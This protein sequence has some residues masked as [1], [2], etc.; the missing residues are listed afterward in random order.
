MLR[1]DDAL[2]YAA[3]IL[4]SRTDWALDS[5]GGS[6][7]DNHDVEVEAIAAVVADIHELAKQFGDPRRYSDGRL[8]TSRAEIQ[9]GFIT[10]H[11][12][13]P[14]VSIEPVGRHSGHLPSGDPDV[15]SPGFYEVTTDPATQD[16]HVRVVRVAGGAV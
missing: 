7:C 15:A 14:D 2:K 12:W 4:K 10:E 6:G 13:H 3:A 8:I 9:P 11:V 1:A 5:I 16:L